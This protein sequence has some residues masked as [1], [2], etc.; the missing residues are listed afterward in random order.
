MG[1][2]AGRCL[3]MHNFHH[4]NRSALRRRM[5]VPIKAS[6]VRR[7]RCLVGRMSVVSTDPCQTMLEQQRV[8]VTD[9]FRIA[10]GL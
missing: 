1:S 7:F 8:T 3:N 2:V 5:D 9:E 6:E 10:A 4:F